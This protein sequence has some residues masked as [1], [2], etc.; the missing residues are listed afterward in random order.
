MADKITL[1]ASKREIF[2]RQVKKLRQQKLIP[3]NVF[4]SHIKSQALTI[5]FEDFRLVYGEAGDSSIV[6][7]KIDGESKDR[8]VLVR[9]PQLHPVTRMPLH[10]DLREV[11]LKE[12]I[13]TMIEVVL[14]GEA[15]ATSQGA[16]IIQL[17]NEVEVEA[18]PTDLPE[19]IEVD[20]TG[21]EK[22]ED[23]ILA[24]DLKID[25]TKVE[26]QLD[27]EEVVVKA[28]APKEEVVE[29][30]A[31]AQEIPAEGEEAKP[32]EGEEAKKEEAD[33]KEE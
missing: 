9:P 31:P 20:I 28:E 24:K 22:I 6:Y 4:G 19:K 1:K 2:G 12:K 14:I 23:M 32:A 5:K 17:K 11:N 15:P 3:A 26:L 16:L 33:K 27:D 13:K 25:R 21:L 8:P 18:L 10:I 29:E 30:E 7:L